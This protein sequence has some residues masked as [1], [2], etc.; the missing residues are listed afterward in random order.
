MKYIDN[1]NVSF[2]VG[3]LP[4]S[5]SH[6]FNYF[7]EWC[8]LDIDDVFEYAKT[9]DA[10][11]VID[12]VRSVNSMLSKIEDFVNLGQ[13]QMPVLD[14]SLIVQLAFEASDALDSCAM[15]LE[16][17]TEK[18]DFRDRFRSNAQ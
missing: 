1:R 12:F 4:E 6:L 9:I 16:T 17:G 2:K 11:R 7:Q 14:A 3:D 10:N 13:Q 5:L 8:F 15:C 18:G